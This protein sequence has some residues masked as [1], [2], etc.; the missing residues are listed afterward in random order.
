MSD[1]LHEIISRHSLL[2]LLV[3]NVTI[4]IPLHDKLTPWSLA[5]YGIC[6][7][8]R[9]GIFIGKVAKPPHFLVTSLALA[10][11]LTLALISH[12]IG[13]LN[14]LIN[15]LILGYALKNIEMKERRDVRIVVL[16]GYFLIAIT[17][18]NQ[19]SILYASLLSLVTIINTC[20]LVS[21]YHEDDNI[22]ETAK[23]GTK[24]ILQSLPLAALLFIVLPKL[25]PLWLIPQS[26]SGN[27]G[28]SNQVHFGD[29]K[30]LTRSA[31]LAFRADFGFNPPA[32]P[33]LYW[34]AL[35]MENYDGQTWTQ[36]TSMSDIEK[37]VAFAVPSKQKATGNALNY[38]VI[39]QP[40]GQ[41]W[42][43]GLD[44]AFSEHSNIINLPDH[45]LYAKRSIDQPFQ[46]SVQSYLSSP[47]DLTLHDTVKQINLALPEKNNPKTRLF[48]E[49]LTREYPEPNNRLLA[50]MSYFNQEN[51]YYTLTPPAVGPQQIDDFLFE[52]KAGFCEHYASSF[53]FISRATGIPA[54]L[55]TGYQGGEWNQQAGYLNV[56]QYM[57]HAWAEV[58]LEGKGWVRFDPTAMIA[59]E[60]V[61][62]GFDAFFQPEASYLL[63]SPFSSLRLRDF[64]LLNTLRISLD[65]LDYYWSV[66]V[67]GFD[68]KKQTHVLQQMLGEVTQE[69]L[70]LLMLFTMALISLTIAYSAGLLTFKSPPET[71]STAYLKICAL[72][73]KNGIPRNLNDG[74]LTYS[75]KVALSLPTIAP[76]F[77]LLT[78]YYIALKYQSLS[79]DNEQE[80]K[81]LFISLFK[82][83]KKQL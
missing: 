34:R 72:F 29:I 17:F 66:W 10:S 73:E 61:L 31:A 71:Y 38:S 30:K 56:Y 2:W 25:S 54:R 42:L 7:L 50:L 3:I 32:N 79:E 39:A 24:L 19:Q 70:S 59:P 67:L 16:V 80:I 36:H 76:E 23:M 47:M 8:W 62:Q 81:K 45:R 53:V 40:S 65:S 51:Y 55:V 13:L 63:D 69:K 12:Q 49:N 52:N 14:G 41:H 6:L 22:K 57:A 28:L 74:P 18:I 60:R 75:K 37:N 9:L 1:T 4:L 48:A 43:F 82:K 11:A 15:L 5:I 26:N 64:P 58:W 27:T 68:S 44:V 77:T 35:V 21:L 20:V 46:Y 33:L 83:I 78:H